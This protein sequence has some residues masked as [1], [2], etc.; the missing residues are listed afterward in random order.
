[1]RDTW[2][3]VI[4]PRFDDDP[5]PAAAQ[6]RA[7]IAI[8]EA[9]KEDLRSTNAEVR[10]WAEQERDEAVAELLPNLQEGSRGLILDYWMVRW[11][12]MRQSQ[13]LRKNIPALVPPVPV[14]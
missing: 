1:M 13:R 10:A 6:V 2:T 4:G 5:H 9:F 7:N 14:P 12:R 3:E 8:L 11:E